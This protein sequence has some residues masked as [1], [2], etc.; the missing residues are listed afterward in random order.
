[1][2]YCETHMVGG[3]A[4]RLVAPIPIATVGCAVRHIHK[5]VLLRRRRRSW[6]NSEIDYSEVL[7]ARVADCQGL[8][9]LGEGSI[10]SA[11]VRSLVAHLDSGGAL[12]DD[13]HLWPRSH[14]WLVLR[15]GT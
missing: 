7:A 8:P 3:S 5:S 9:R 10:P 2:H 4:G 13:E 15:P 14:G 1:M 6:S 11:E 12:H